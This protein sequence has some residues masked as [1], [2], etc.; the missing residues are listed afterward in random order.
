MGPQTWTVKLFEA[1]TSVE[2][3][4]TKKAADP[5]ETF[6]VSAAGS[7]AAKAAA[8]SWL[9]SRGHTVRTIGVSASKDDKRT[10][11]VYVK[12]GS[13]SESRAFLAAQ[14]AKRVPHGLPP[15]R[16]A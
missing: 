7:D 10:L 1:R 2:F 12:A 6:G 5:I 8:R 15:K 14:A 11:I 4:K 16:T 3:S 9:K 13:G